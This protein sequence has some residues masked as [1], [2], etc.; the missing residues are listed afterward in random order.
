MRNNNSQATK[1]ILNIYDIID[2]NYYL[3][4][5]GLGAYH[6]GVVINDTEYSFGY[7]ASREKRKKKNFFFLIF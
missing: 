3:H 5:V 4:G 2:Q 6:T 1:V 7:N